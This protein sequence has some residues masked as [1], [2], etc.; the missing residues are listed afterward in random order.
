[1]L[2]QPLHRAV[3]RR[4]Q[5]C[6]GNEPLSSTKYGSKR[7][8]LGVLVLSAPDKAKEFHRGREQR[9]AQL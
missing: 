1:M 3:P 4:C 7:P 6:L 8:V 9:V 2:L 5:R